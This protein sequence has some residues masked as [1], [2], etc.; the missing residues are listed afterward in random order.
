MLP[1]IVGRISKINSDGTYI[2]HRDRPKETRFIGRRVWVRKEW[3][4]P[5]QTRDVTDITDIYR[6]CYPRTFVLPQGLELTYLDSPNGKFIVSPKFIW[7]KT[8]DNEIIHAVNLF[9][10]LFDG[11]EIRH[12]NLSPFLHP[13]IQRVNWTL[14]PPGS[15]TSSITSHVNSLIQKTKPTFRKPIT[16]RL[17]FVASKNPNHVFLGNGGFH[18]YVAY[19]FEKTGMTILESIMPANATYIFLG[20]W[21]N[22]SQLTKTQILTSGLYHDRIIHDH[23]WERSITPYME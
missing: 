2:I 3:A 8:P 6:D 7:R 12:G 23:R 15:T 1:N 16:D 20:N 9:L 22:V 14:L 13:N 4:G 10:E 17:T 18:G 5:G 11:A 19:I 21:S